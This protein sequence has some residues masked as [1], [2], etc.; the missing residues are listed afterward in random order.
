MGTIKFT[1]TKVKLGFKKE[2]PTVYKIQQVNYGVVETEALIDDVAEACG[3]NRAMTKA[4]LEGI[5]SRVCR[6]IGMG[7]AVQ[8]G[9]LGTV[10]PYFTA[11]TKETADELGADNVRNKKIRFYP[12]ARLQKVVKGISVSEYD[13]ADGTI[14]DE[15]A[16][17]PN[18]N[19]TDPDNGSNDNGEGGSTELE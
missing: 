7:H 11:K 19:P 13:L 18:D 17:L 15:D 6:Y 16:E 9:E 10:K 3:L 12:G 5:V 4:A 8:L 1:K 2:K 14:I